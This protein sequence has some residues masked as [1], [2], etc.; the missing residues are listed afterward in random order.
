V[1]EAG[2]DQQVAQFL[3][4]YMMMM[5]MMTTMDWFITN[6]DGVLSNAFLELTSSQQN[7]P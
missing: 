6:I 3:D 7:R 1:C 5:M 2:T 4:S